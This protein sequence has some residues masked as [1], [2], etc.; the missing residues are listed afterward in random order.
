M[1][2]S[3]DKFKNKIVLEVLIKSIVIGLSLGLIAFSI[4]YT[5]YK[6]TGI[7]Y[8]LLYVILIPIGIWI[9]VSGLVFL[10]LK[11]S[12]KKIAK[13]IDKSLN[14]NEKVQTMI[15]YE[16]DDNFMINLQREDTLDILSKISI[17][18][19]SMKFGVFFFLICGIAALSCITAL[20]VPSYEEPPVELPPEI[21]V[22]IDNWTIQAIKDLISEVEE[23][24]IDERLK[25]KYVSELNNLILAIDGK[26]LLESELKELVNNV[27]SFVQLEVD[28]VNTNNEVYTVLK[29]S[30][31]SAVVQFA[32]QINLLNPQ[33]VEISL[34]MIINLI[35]GNKDAI[36]ELNPE[37]GVL[38]K[39]SNLNK[40]D[41]LYIALINMVDA[42]NAC[43]NQPDVYDAVKTAVRT[44]GT[45]IVEIVEV[46]AQNQ[47]IAD[48]I[49]T[50]LKEIFNIV[51]EDTDLGGGE[52]E[53]QEGDDNK[54]NLPT[55]NSGGAGTGEVLFGSDDKFFDPEEGEVNYGDVYTKYYGDIVGKFADGVIPQELRDYFDR[56]FDIL[57][58]D[59]EDQA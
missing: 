51:D 47:Y 35:N 58:G 33:K 3:F 59:I 45:K 13:R 25:N 50:T 46:Q 1:N 21:E 20:A 15:E 28:K 5:Y 39:N 53:G 19:L 26:T 9:I 8:N 12:K 36:T 48:Y 7:E 34:D 38:L 11:P 17:K 29:E 52:G 40:D 10:I 30:S 23:S 16:K 49:E 41:E 18:S 56:Y 4:P 32:L 2:Y 42:I 14:L 44:N 37:F 6:V 54:N 57:Q 55:N 43:A 27:I 24:N 31:T 22:E